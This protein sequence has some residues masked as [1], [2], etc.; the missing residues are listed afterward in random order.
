MSGVRHDGR[1][2]SGNDLPV[3]EAT[4]PSN[5]AL[6]PTSLPPEAFPSTC[7]RALGGKAAAELV[8]YAPQ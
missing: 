4:A 5:H 8:R 7:G 6:Q 3:S 2:F 1:L